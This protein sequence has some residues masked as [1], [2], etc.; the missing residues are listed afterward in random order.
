MSAET[1]QLDIINSCSA[2]GFGSPTGFE[3][4]QRQAKMLSASSLVP[5][6]YSIFDKTGKL[7]SDA[8]QT[9]AQANA[10]I[11]IEMSAR[12]GA[13]PIMVAQNL[14]IV[15]GRPGWSSQFIIAA[16]NASG[17]FSPLRF[18]I[19]GDGDDK[20]CVAWA[21]EN[22]TGDRLESAPVSISMAKAEGWYGKNGS[23]WKT[24]PD[25]MLRYRAASFFGRVYAPEI[26]MGIKGMEEIDDII[27]IDR[28]QP[29]SANSIVVD[30]ETPTLEVTEKS[31]HDIDAELAE[32]DTQERQEEQRQQ[33]SPG[34]GF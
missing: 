18:D 4:L 33:T 22:K 27:D 1:K 20:T 5:E 12:I 25:L 6:Q 32:Q 16:I 30:I 29:V 15:H 14:Y 23:K 3:M 24:M 11:A 13:S 9:Y 34:P 10:A 19:K 7:K 26:L 28:E 31:S 8:E 2:V 21:V 17:K